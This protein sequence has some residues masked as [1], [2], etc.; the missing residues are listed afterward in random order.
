MA[1]E[2]FVVYAAIVDSNGTFNA[3]SGYPKSFDSK[4][5]SDDVQKAMNRAYADY[6]EVVG[7]F[8]KRDDRKVQMATI[9]NA[10]TGFQM[11]HTAIGLLNESEPEED[12]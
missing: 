3:L 5:Y 8:Y 7:A 4:N 12:E 2:I 11:E 6:H 10:A 1:R 9:L